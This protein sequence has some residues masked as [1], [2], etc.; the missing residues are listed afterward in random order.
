MY[1]K[2]NKKNLKELSLLPA[3]TK[4]QAGEQQRG[5]GSTVRCVRGVPERSIKRPVPADVGTR[6][7]EHEPEDGQT[8]VHAT[9]DVHE[10]PGHAAH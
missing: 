4:K 1:T 7:E 9:G 10:E 5:G 3:E 8:E 2:K 6:R